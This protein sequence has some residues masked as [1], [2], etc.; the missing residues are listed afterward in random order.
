MV[1]RCT[2]LRQRL[3]WEMMLVKLLEKKKFLLVEIDQGV[4]VGDLGL[5]SVEVWSL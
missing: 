2:E 3:L 1:S 5:K 4:R